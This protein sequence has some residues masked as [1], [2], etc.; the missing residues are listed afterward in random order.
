MKYFGT[1]GI[2]GKYGKWPVS[3]EFAHKLGSAL[4]YYMGK[5]SKGRRLLLGMDTRE[6]GPFLANALLDGFASA[7]GKVDLVGVAPTPAIAFGV[8][9]GTYDMGVVISASHN[10]WIYNGF[11]LF[12]GSGSKLSKVEEERI[13]KILEEE[14][15]LEEYPN[16][17]PGKIEEFEDLY[18]GFLLSS[19]GT[20]DALKGFCV[21]MDCANGSIS[22]YAPLLFERLG[23]RWEAYFCNPDGKN[24]NE[25]C[26]SEHPQVLAKKMKRGHYDLGLCFDGDGDRLVAIDEK[27]DVLSG[28]HLLYI[29]ALY[30]Y[31]K[32]GLR[33]NKL[34]TTIMSNRGLK[35]ALAHLGI[36]VYE[37]D[38]GDRNVFFEMRE[39]D[40]LLGGEESG[41][42]IFGDRHSTGDG[43]LSA[44]I[45]MEAMAYFGK[46]LSEL[47]SEFK[48]FP[49][50]M[51]NLEVGKK[52]PLDQIPG[53]LP[54]LEGQRRDLGDRGKIVVRYS[55]TEPL[56]RVMVEA[57]D[58]VKVKKILDE[59]TQRLSPYTLP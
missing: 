25:G 45:L 52:I 23:A 54:F 12:D 46:P 14:I 26:G 48:P 24:I 28:D 57:E 56:I 38:V 36:L 49:K 29:F 20:K 47:A 15:S 1:D 17:G 58:E 18:L 11:K 40:A 10:P 13:E 30:L 35:V 44:L 41:H 21:L 6:S 19:V 51:K 42:I 39:R 59:I 27:G 33:G 4:F 50:G 34:V 43:L 31:S 37:T 8:R 22:S 2:R 7:G 32:G 5:G 55:G 16:Q 53:F 3:E 9:K